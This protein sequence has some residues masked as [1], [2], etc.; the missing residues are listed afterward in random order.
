[1]IRPDQRGQTL[2]EFA[3]IVPV[4]LLVVIG[5]FDVGRGVFA[6]NTV[7]NAARGAARVAIVDQDPDAIRAEA[8]RLG[9]ALGLSDAD[10]ELTAC[11]EFDCV[12]GVT[13]TY[14]YDAATPLIGQ[15]FDP[16]I[17]STARMPVENVNP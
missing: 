10:I 8:K 6:Y 4:F 14:D 16:T 2:V 3:L 12:Y 15:L 7:A 1:M 17:T 13:V 5:L 11:S 9:V